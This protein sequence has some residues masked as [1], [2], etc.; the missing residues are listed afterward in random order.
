MAIQPVA[1]RHGATIAQI[2]IAWTLAQSGVTFALCGARNPAQALDNAHAG[3][4]QLLAD[5]L[6]L[7]DGAISAQLVDMDG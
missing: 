4:L 7:I 1:D 2:V 5:D 3:K 6:A